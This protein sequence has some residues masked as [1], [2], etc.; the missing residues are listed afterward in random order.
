MKKSERLLKLFCN[1]II[2]N[3]VC[4]NDTEESD[5][6]QN[7]A[8]VELSKVLKGT[9][10]DVRKL[11]VDDLSLLTLF[12]FEVFK[13]NKPSETDEHYYGEI[14]YTVVCATPNDVIIQIFD[15]F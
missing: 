11:T 4:I 14:C 6:G 7:V 2:D 5:F 10:I 12:N 1:Y 3:K 9:N 13:D 8:N 15:G